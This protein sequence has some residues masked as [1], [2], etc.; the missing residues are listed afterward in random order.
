MLAGLHDTSCVGPQTVHCPS[1]LA[2]RM[3]RELKLRGTTFYQP[4]L[5]S[6]ETLPD[7][8]QLREKA[9]IRS[10]VSKASWPGHGACS[11][12]VQLNSQQACNPR[13]I[14]GDSF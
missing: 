5:G 2:P 9:E 8:F 1:P 14:R 11:T 13:L 10:L 6:A 4:F 12:A 3:Q 7:A